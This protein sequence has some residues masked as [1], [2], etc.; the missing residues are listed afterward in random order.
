MKKYMLCMI[1]VAVCVCFARPGLAGTIRCASTTSTQNSGLFDYL[2]PIFQKDTGVEVQVIAVG[3][4]AAL[5]L[6]E[7]GDVDVAFVHAKES[8]LAKVQEGWFVD[9]RDVMDNDFIIV[10]PKSDP[11]KMKSAKTVVEAFKSIPASRSLFVSRGDDSG[12]H[13]KELKLWKETGSAPDAATAKWYLSVGQGMSKALRI[14]AEKKAYVLTDRGTWLSMKDKDNL[15]L[16]LV[17]EG[18]PKLF[19][20]YGVMLVNPAKHPAVN[21]ADGKKFID[22]LVSAKGQQT[23]NS[24]KD[25]NGN[26]MFIAN[27]KK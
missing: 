19:N 7:K 21:V 10:G 24:F 13:Q 14:A 11:A 27:A 25:A 2:L 26:S 23:I 6:G 20:Q 1:G 12:T 16:A 3:T 9:R 22:W 5:K 4:G 8:E 17:F 15:D 18:D